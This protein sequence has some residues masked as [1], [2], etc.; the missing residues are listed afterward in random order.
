MENEYITLIAPYELGSIWTIECW[1]WTPISEDS[2][3]IADA[4]GDNLPI[5]INKYELG[6]LTADIWGTSGYNT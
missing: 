5:Y 3:L 1:T 2:I 6:L 4:T